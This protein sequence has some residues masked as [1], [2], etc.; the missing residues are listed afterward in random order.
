MSYPTLFNSQRK[1]A[2]VWFLG[3][4]IVFVI[5]VGQTTIGDKFVTLTVPPDD[6]ALDVWKWFLPSV[7]PTLGLV[8]GVL[9]NNEVHEEARRSAQARSVSP[10]FFSTSL[11]LSMFYLALV[12][13]VVVVTPYQADVEARLRFLTKS[14]LF[15]APVQALLS[16][17]LGVF[18]ISTKNPDLP[19]P[20]PAATGLPPA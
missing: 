6:R 4:A 9:A 10:F 13:F 7:T 19:L 5:V 1:L 20:A 15:L 14:H 11:Y 18:F 12:A 2:V 17:A 16:V 8:M 3:A